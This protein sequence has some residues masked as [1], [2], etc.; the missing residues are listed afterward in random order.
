MAGLENP[1]RAQHRERLA[2]GNSAD[3]E[4]LLQRSLTGN[5]LVRGPLAA[6]N[7]LEHLFE[8]ALSG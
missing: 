8:Q 7:T 6:A 4:L 1:Q 2:Q 5:W 3:A